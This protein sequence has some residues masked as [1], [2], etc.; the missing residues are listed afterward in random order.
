[1]VDE[2]SLQFKALWALMFK[3]KLRLHVEAEA[4]HCL[5]NS[6]KNSSKKSMLQGAMLLG[7]TLANVAHGPFNSGTNALSK[8]RAA[9]LFSKELSDAEFRSLREE[10]L[11]DRAGEDDDA[12]IPECPSDIPHLRTVA[13][14]GAFARVPDF[15]VRAL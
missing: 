3:S 14:L 1:M 13:T 10:M 8:Q 5:W 12:G 15:V 7:T 6:V 2:E 4:L 11:S 9:E